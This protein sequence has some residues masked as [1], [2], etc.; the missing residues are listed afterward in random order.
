MW[1]N[2]DYSEKT[3]YDLPQVK[4]FV[5]LNLGTFYFTNIKTYPSTKIKWSFLKGAL[6]AKIVNLYYP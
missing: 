6:S 3:T 2:P 4:I 5:L 1:K